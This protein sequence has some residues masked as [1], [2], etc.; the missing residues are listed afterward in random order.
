MHDCIV[1]TCMMCLISY[2]VRLRVIIAKIPFVRSHLYRSTSERYA[3]ID[4]AVTINDVYRGLDGSCTK[5][6]PFLE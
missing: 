2:N 4:S 1:H 6:P 5:T 3:V